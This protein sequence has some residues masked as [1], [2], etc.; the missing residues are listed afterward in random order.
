M[1]TMHAPSNR[2][3]ELDAL[4][5]IAAILVMLFHYTTRYDELFGHATP[6]AFAVPWGYLGLNLFFMISGFVIFMTLDRTR[7]PLDFVVS[8]FSRLYPAYWIAVVATFSVLALFHLPGKTQ[9]ALTAAGN[10]AMFHNLFGVAHVDNVYWTLEV[11][12]L[13]YALMLML[14]CAGALQRPFA[15]IAAWLG[16]RLIYFIAAAAGT[17]LPYLVTR[18]LILDTFPYFAIGMAV[19]LR[20][21]RP[22]PEQWKEPATVLA[23]LLLIG[24]TESA[25]QALATAL[26]TALFYLAATHRLTL[27]RWTPLV[28]LGAI[29]YPFY[30]L[31]EN[32]GWT[33]IF[34]LEAAQWNPHAA[35]AAALVIALLAATL[36]HVLVEKPAM[37][38]IRR[39]YRAHRAGE[40]QF[41]ARAWAGGVALSLGMLAAA[42][43]LAAS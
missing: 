37:E 17:D 5:G 23:A 34:Q 27:L 18:I 19:Y 25:M 14:W 22:A 1:L 21:T 13:F 7:H 42:N 32:I 12:L 16:L 43:K 30:L 39:R 10:L 8:R 4:R 38:A 9:T 35:I 3:L 24:I 36:L 20:V 29:S 15:I 26:F 11:E 2:L 40:R 33:V 31:H 6:V 41:S 28:W